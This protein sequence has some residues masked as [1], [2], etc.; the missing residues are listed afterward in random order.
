M[1]LAYLISP[2]MD[3]TIKATTNPRGYTE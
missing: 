2:P 1:Y 3:Y